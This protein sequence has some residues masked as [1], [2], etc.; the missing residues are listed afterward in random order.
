MTELEDWISE[1]EEEEEE[2]ED[3]AEDDCPTSSLTKEEK[4]RL[5][6]PWKQTLIIK[7]LAEGPL[8]TTCCSVK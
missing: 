1:D 2:T 3:G 7:L 5:R 6:R 4:A 8:A